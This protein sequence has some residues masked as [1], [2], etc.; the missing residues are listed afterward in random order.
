MSL[1]L[2]GS[3]SG[4]VELDAP[5]AAGSNTL[6]LP[7]GNGTSGQ[8]LKTDGSGNLSWTGGQ[9]LQTVFSSTETQ[10]GT[11]ST[12]VLEPSNV[13]GSITPIATNSRLLILT[14]FGVQNSTATGGVAV[15]LRY[16]G[17]STNLWPTADPT[18]FQYSAG[19]NNIVGSALNYVDATGSW[20]GTISYRIYFKAYATGTATINHGTM[21]I[22][23][24][25]A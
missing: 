14:T 25:A 19:G 21:T 7:D 8:Y 23:E 2:N 3:T 6:V 17:G 15:V 16:D 20:S 1:R 10:A 9:V 22:M 24:L 5:A 13:T 4:Y 18:L 12:S 11:T